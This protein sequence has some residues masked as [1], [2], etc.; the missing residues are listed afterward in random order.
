MISE[1][2]VFITGAGTVSALGRGV[3]AAAGALRSCRSGIS[4]PDVFRT[5][6]R[7][8]PVGEVKID[9]ADLRGLLAKHLPVPRVATRAALLGMLALDEALANAG[10]SPDDCRHVVLVSATA[11][12]GMD[13]TEKYYPGPVRHED[14]LI[15]FH[16]CGAVTDVMAERYGGFAMRTTVSTACSASLNAI[17]FGCDLIRSGRAGIVVAGGTECLTEYHLNGFNS[18]RILDTDRCRPFDR[19]RNGLNLG[20]GAGFVVLESR[21]SV[22]R[23]NAVPVAAVAGYANRCDSYHQTASS[24][25][26]EGAFLCMKAALDGAS[27]SPG[28]ISY[29]NAHGTGTPNNDLSEGRAVERV[30]GSAVPPISSTKAFTGHTTAAS[31]A[32]ESVFSLIAMAEGFLPVSLGFSERMDEL[33]FDPV[34]DGRASAP[35]ER[36]MVNAFGFGGN[37][38]CI[39]YENL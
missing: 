26:G 27:L 9:N 25:S 35:L 37:D 1:R 6:H 11:V 19:S 33:S 15:R 38:S 12:G 8:L 28:S 2:E 29:I 31:G 16:D 20:E 5:A 34:T 3:G 23:R 30:F 10:L 24:P 39:I 32:I 36:V 17:I 13:E 4:L 22:L 18:L 21:S 7:E 14:N